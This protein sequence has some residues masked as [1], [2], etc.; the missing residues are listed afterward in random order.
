MRWAK[1]NSGVQDDTDLALIRPHQAIMV[2]EAHGAPLEVDSGAVGEHI[3]HVPKH[4]NHP[5]PWARS[6]DSNSRLSTVSEL[7]S[8]DLHVTE[9]LCDARGPGEHQPNG[10]LA[11]DGVRVNQEVRC[12]AIVRLLNH[13][14]IVMGNDFAVRDSES[15]SRK[16]ANSTGAGDGGVE[17]ASI[18]QVIPSVGADLVPDLHRVG[19]GVDKG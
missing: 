5:E 10:C 18:D 12:W 11:L 1:G 3:N 6:Q 17:H 15:S 14:S 9:K 13:E 7:V 2:Y 19:H 8:V 16:P 4:L